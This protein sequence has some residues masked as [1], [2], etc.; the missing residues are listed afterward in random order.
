MS[1]IFFIRYA[2]ETVLL[3]DII[4]FRTEIDVAPGYL[5][6]EFYL[7]CELFYCLPP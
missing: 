3:R 1:K 2:E 4:K 7:K 6:T 5:N